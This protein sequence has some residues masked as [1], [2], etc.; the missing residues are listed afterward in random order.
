V[1]VSILRRV[2]AQLEYGADASGSRRALFLFAVLLAPHFLNDLPLLAAKTAE[3][4]LAIDY[5]ARLLPLAL[6]VAIPGLRRAAFSGKRTARR[7]AIIEA[8][9]V[10]LVIELMIW[11]WFQPF[12]LN[13]LGLRSDPTRLQSFIAI[14]DRDLRRFDLTV[15]LLLVAVEEELVARRMFVHLV[16]PRFG[17]RESVLVI[18][19]SLMFGVVHWSSGL[20]VVLLATLTGVFLML[21]LRGTGVLWPGI[22]VHYL[23]NFSIFI[24]Q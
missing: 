17:N 20:L 2:W 14:Q 24:R 22:V 18:G 12:L 5:V 19:S 21:L 3:Q 11:L 4:W 1:S 9:F 23:V 8:I 16:G 10:V 15:G 6:I 7:I 13:E